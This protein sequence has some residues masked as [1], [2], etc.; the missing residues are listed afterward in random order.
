M[1]DSGDGKVLKEWQWDVT[2]KVCLLTS[3]ENS[4]T[5]WAAL[6][7]RLYKHRHIQRAGKDVK[8]NLQ[9]LVPALKISCQEE[10]EETQAFALVS[11]RNLRQIKCTS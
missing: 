5:C 9:R 1:S 8:R 7:Q 2:V 4:E 3:N 6:C 11:F 10:E